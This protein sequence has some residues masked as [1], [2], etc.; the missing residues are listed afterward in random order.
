M[1]RKAIK[2][3]EKDNVA[4]ALTDIQSGEIVV[5]KGVKEE[6]VKV[7]QDIPFGHKIALMYI[8]EGSEII[9]Y[10]EVIGRATSGIKKGEHVHVH[11]V[12]SL[13]GRGDLSKVDAAE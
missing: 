1:K 8:P 4:T 13:R 6:E 3:N 7:V 11:N 10:G 9:K 12:E 5:I 2:I